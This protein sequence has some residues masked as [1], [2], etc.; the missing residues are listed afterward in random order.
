MPAMPHKKS[1]L[2][3][4]LALACGA[5]VESAAQKCELSERTVYKR[6]ADPSF[7]SQVLAVRGDMVS[8]AAG[9][10]TGSALESIQTLR[11]LQ[12]P[13]HPPAVRLGAA[14]AVLEMGTRLREVSDLEGQIVELRQM[15]NTAQGTAT[16]AAK[17][18]S[19]ASDRQSRS[20]LKRGQAKPKRRDPE[21]PRE[22]SNGTGQPSQ[23]AE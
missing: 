9:A 12:R 7:K 13:A 5:S 23:N 17:V 16:A 19:P 18:P 10:L 2:P 22:A 8:R 21:A 1:D 3:L 11:E 14:R 15:L 4:L 6:L 20:G